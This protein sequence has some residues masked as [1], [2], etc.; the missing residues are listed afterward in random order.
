MHKKYGDEE[1]GSRKEDNHDWRRNF[2]MRNEGIKA[3]APWRENKGTR[4]MDIGR[5]DCRAINAKEI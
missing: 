3:R 2:R 4:N 5:K 1:W